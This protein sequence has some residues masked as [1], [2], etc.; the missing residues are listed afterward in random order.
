VDP[1]ANHPAI[2][3]T[4]ASKAR[5]KDRDSKFQPDN[6][7]ATGNGKAGKSTEEK[8]ACTKKVTIEEALGEIEKR[9]AGG[10]QQKGKQGASSGH[11]DAKR[12]AQPKRVDP[13]RT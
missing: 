8:E 11:K 6:A 5:R 7:T 10:K 12:P 3:G 2:K 4:P 13:V 1:L 9:K